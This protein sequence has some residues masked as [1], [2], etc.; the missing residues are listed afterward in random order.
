MKHVISYV[1]FFRRKILEEARTIKRSRGRIM[2]IF[3]SYSHKDQLIV[4]HLAE[5]IR[6][7][8]GQENVIF[9]QWS[10]QPGDSIIGSLDQCKGG[11]I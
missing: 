1:I 11:L 10:I 4:A 8:F 5:V 9:D 2:S 6:T 7:T 3:I